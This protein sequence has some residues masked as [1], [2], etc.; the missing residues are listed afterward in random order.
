LANLR[1]LIAGRQRL[2]IQLTTIAARRASLHEEQID[3]E[4]KID[5]LDREIDDV[6]RN[7][8]LIEEIEIGPPG[9]WNEPND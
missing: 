5:E 3:L 8:P 9:I 1:E 7:D 2:V 6:V 4:C